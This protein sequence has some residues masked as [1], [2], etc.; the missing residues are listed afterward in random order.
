MFPILLQLPSVLEKPIF[1][2][3]YLNMEYIFNKILQF[4]DAL[5]RFFRGG[6]SVGG[7]P[8][9]PDWRLLSIIGWVCIAIL[10]ALILY[11]LHKLSLLRYEERKKYWEAEMATLETFDHTEHDIKWQKVENLLGMLGESDWRLAIVEAD[12]ILADMLQKMGYVGDSIGDKLKAIEP[13]DFLTLNDA[14]EAHK[15]RNRIAHEGTNFR[16]SHR[17]AQRVIALYKKVFEEFHYI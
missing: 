16:L 17:E 8:E 11:V 5:V 13:S 4:V 14:W 10:F 15:I 3:R 2:P 1:E 12:N 9:A 6:I 7:V